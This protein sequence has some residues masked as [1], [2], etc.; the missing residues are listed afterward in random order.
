ML[1]V[2][3]TACTARAVCYRHASLL[4]VDASAR[5][6]LGSGMSASPPWRTSG[7]GGTRSDRGRPELD[8]E[9]SKGGEHPVTLLLTERHREAPKLLKCTAHWLTFRPPQNN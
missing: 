1:Y 2:P 4:P 9:E 3:M 5:C 8:T 6:C 7:C